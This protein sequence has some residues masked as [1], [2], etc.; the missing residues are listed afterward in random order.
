MFDNGINNEIKLYL[1]AIFSKIPSVLYSAVITA[2]LLQSRLNMTQIGTVWSIILFTSVV[3]DYLTGGFADRYGRLRLYLLGMLCMGFARIA[4]ALGADYSSLIYL[5]AILL[6]AGESQVNGTIF[7]WFVQANG[8]LG[9]NDKNY[10]TRVAAQSQYISNGAGI[11]AGVLMSLLPLNYKN[12]LLIAGIVQI[13]GGILIYSLSE[14]NKNGQNKSF[15]A[16]SIGSL[17]FYKDAPILWV[18]TIALTMVYSLYT[19]YLFIWQPIGANFGFQNSK[20]GW[21]QSIYVAAM[22]ASGLL[23]KYKRGNAYIVYILSSIA[24]PIALYI[25]TINKVKIVYIALVFIYGFSAG[26]LMPIIMGSM[27]KYISNEAR[28]SVVSLVSS[29]SSLVLVFLQIIIGRIIDKTS[30]SN[31]FQVC[32]IIGAI[33]LTSMLYIIGQLKRGLDG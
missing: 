29:I 17:K 31:L 19:I 10:L 14:D 22:V 13:I 20:N 8:S 16:I 32:F 11:L 9:G 3:L 12:I 24:A 15:K 6:G 23:I 5:G 18:Y 7:P 28:S 4:I 27:H 21:I 25:M 33:L 30:Y 1:G 26:M 2:F